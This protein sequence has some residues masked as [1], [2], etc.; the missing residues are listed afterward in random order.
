MLPFGSETAK[1]C[2]FVYMTSR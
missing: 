1:T 2:T